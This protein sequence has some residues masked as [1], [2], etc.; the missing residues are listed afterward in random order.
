VTDKIPGVSRALR[1]VIAFCARHVPYYCDQNWAGRL[2]AGR[3]VNLP[4]IPYTLDSDVKK[5][6]AAFYSRFVPPEHGAVTDKFTSG[7][8]GDSLR[9]PKTALHFEIN[10]RQNVA[11]KQG[12]GVQGHRIV[13]S[14]DQA[15]TEHPKGSVQDKGIGHRRKYVIRSFE[16]RE[17]ARLVE[18]SGATLLASRPS[19]VH[20]TLLESAHDLSSLEL[21]TTVGESLSPQFLH[22]LRQ[23]PKLRHFDGYGAVETGII[24]GKCCWCGVYHIAGDHLLTE[25]TDGQARPVTEGGVGSV[26]VTPL[27]NYAMPLLK[28][29]LGDIV[30]RAGS[31]ACPFGSGGFTRIV[32][33]ERH[34]FLLPNGARITPN[35]GTSV[36]LELG[37]KQYRL[38]QTAIDRVEFH[39]VTFDPSAVLADDVVR[40]L[41]A[42]NIGQGVLGIG[43]KSDAILPSAS[44]KYLMH[45]SRLQQAA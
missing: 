25:V 11:L 2:R 42:L 1:D 14:T 37:V 39:Y 21:V 24:A 29:R 41:V 16:S 8:T 35:V 4:E 36:L 33:R 44:G 7:F 18:S 10:A 40:N 20:G 30:E 34:Q 43:V 26:A 12:W 9:V 38:V 15:N 19:V 3:P 22:T 6:P 27:F 32:G 23:Y 17:I 5:D 45:E 28:Y 13:V 31:E